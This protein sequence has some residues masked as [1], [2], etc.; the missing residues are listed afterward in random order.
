MYISSSLSSS[1]CSSTSSSINSSFKCDYVPSSPKWDRDLIPEIKAIVLRY[2]MSKDRYEVMFVSKSWKAACR[3]ISRERFDKATQI[4][5]VLAAGSIIYST[6]SK[7]G[8][9][10]IFRLYKK[11]LAIRTPDQLF[12]SMDQSH[13]KCVDFRGRYVIFELNERIV[14]YVNCLEGGMRSLRFEDD[15]LVENI[16]VAQDESKNIVAVTSFYHKIEKTKLKIGITRDGTVLFFDTNGNPYK[17]WVI[18]NI[19]LKG[20]VVS[21][22]LVSDDL[23]F[24]VTLMHDVGSANMHVIDIYTKKVLIELEADFTGFDGNYFIS[25]V[26]N[27]IRIYKY[28]LQDIKEGISA[29][30]LINGVIGYVQTNSDWSQFK[31]PKSEGKFVRKFIN[32]FTNQPVVYKFDRIDFIKSID[33]FVFFGR[34]SLSILHLPTQTLI[35]DKKEV[36]GL[37]EIFDISFDDDQL[38][39]LGNFVCEKKAE[40][41]EKGEKVKDE[42]N[43]EEKT[44]LSLMKFNLS[45][46]VDEKPEGLPTIEK[47]IPIP[48]LNKG[49]FDFIAYA[50]NL[51]H[52]MNDSLAVDEPV[53]PAADGE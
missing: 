33:D 12:T 9:S 15:V 50:V 18:T 52:Q 32:K 10:Q 30:R 28:D 47:V 44:T 29:P 39:I 35:A 38:L 42:E 48:V 46:L 41:E 27:P 16:Q 21:S 49:Y 24:I 14:S 17:S 43:G 22:C 25:V 11:A 3:Q 20:Y 7:R 19:E 13:W 34:D 45:K 26:S 1:V 40:D 31:L 8:G 51:C 23:L 6:E 53:A 2:L 5:R 37:K 4:P 36:K